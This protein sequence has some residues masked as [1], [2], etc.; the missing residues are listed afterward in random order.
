MGARRAGHRGALDEGAGGVGRAEDDTGQETGVQVGP[1]RHEGR[2][3]REAAGGGAARAHGLEDAERHDREDEAEEMGPGQPVDLRGDGGQQEDE[4]R[5]QRAEAGADEA[6][7]EAVEGGGDKRGGEQ[8]HAVEA[9]GL[10]GG[11]VEGFGQPFPVEEG[12]ARVGPGEDVDAGDGAVAQ[13]GRSRRGDGAPCPR[14]R[15]AGSSGPAPAPARSARTPLRPG[16]ARAA[17]GGVG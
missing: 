17:H 15:S 5:R 11:G 9:G 3:P 4:Q 2:E 8:G 13:D 6:A 16:V 10:V 14:R 7:I 12:L 1:E